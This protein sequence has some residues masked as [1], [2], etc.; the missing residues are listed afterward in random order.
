VRM[1]SYVAFGVA[2]VA[3]VA[4][5]GCAADAP[6]EPTCTTTS[7]CRGGRVCVDMRCIAR[8]DGGAA[9]DAGATGGDGAVGRDSG[10]GG[11]DGATGADAAACVPVGTTETVCDGRDDDCNGITDDVD[12]AGDG[13]CD[14]LAIGILGAP[15]ANPSSSFQAWLTSRG[16]T[17]T[18]FGVDAAEPLARATLDA[19]DVVILDWL[20]R[21]YT[22]DEAATLRDFVE[23]GGGVMVMTGHD[24]GSDRVRASSLLAALGVEYLAGLVDGP[25]TMFDPHPLTTGLASVTFAG[26]YHVGTTATLGTATSTVVARLPGGPAGIA[27]ERGIGR[28]FAWG[29]EWVEFD[30][31]WS[32]MPMIVGFWTN[33]LGWLAPRATCRTLI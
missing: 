17:T 23:A 26:G 8:A 1:T 6:A 16:T 11:A 10:A 31:E 28:V 22:A 21:E 20:P 18:R 25:V 4:L 14:C 27:I 3:A 33:A 13:I 5:G 9:M 2:V 7:D 24:G 29:D 30:S 15:G 19:Y 12:A 32:T